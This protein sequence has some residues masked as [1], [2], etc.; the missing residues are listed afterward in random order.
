M[1]G[2][3]KVI[4]VCLTK[5]H[6]ICRADYINRLHFLSE[7]AGCKMIVFNSFSD[8]Y[9]ND[10]SD[11]GA[12]SVYG[13]I[14]FDIVDVLVVIYNSFHNK[15][16]IED[17]VSRAKEAGKPVIIINGNVDGCWSIC[18]DYKDTYKAMLNHI[19]KDHGVDDTFFIAG[20]NADT[21]IDSITRLACY[22]EVL[23]EN[24]IP[25]DMKKVAYGDYWEFPVHEIVCRLIEYGQKPPKAIFCANDY[26]AFAACKTLKENGY[27]V[28]EDVIVTGFDGVPAAEYF[29]PQLTTCSEDAE[30][31]ARMTIG[32]VEK[33]VDE[34][35]PPENLTYGYKVVVSESCGCKKLAD[36][37]FRDT[38]LDLHYSISESE[39]HEGFIYAC[40]DHM[41]NINDMN[42]LCSCLA[43]TIL[44]NSYVCLN[45]NF[46]AKTIDAN[47]I[48]NSTFSDELIIINSSYSYNE[49]DIT[50]NI[51]VTDMVPNLEKWVDDDK[52]YYLTAIHSGSEVIGYYAA[53]TDII[54]KHASQINR[55]M[56]AITIAF[57]VAINHFR[58]VKMRLSLDTVTMTNPITSLPNFKGLSRWFEEFSSVQENHKKALSFSVYALPKY[59][60][61]QENYGMADIEA[62]VKFIGEALKIANP[63]NCF[64]AHISDDEFVVVNYYSDIYTISD[65][66]NNATGVFF[67]VVEGYNSTSGKEYY[68]EANA[69]CTVIDPDWN[70]NIEGYIK[71]ANSEMYM[72]RLKYGV[73]IGA[74]E[75]IAPKEHY[76]AFELLIEKNLFMYNFQPIVSA[77]TGEIFAFEALMRTDK[78]IGMNPLQVL[79]AAK[80]YNRL[81]DVEKATMFN[82]M[83]C[84]VRGK[85]YFGDRK[86]F[87]NTIPG[88]FLNDKDREIF[89]EKYGQYTSNCIFEITE[90]ESVSDEELDIIKKLCGGNNVAID[91]YGSGHSN[92]V[93]LMRYAPQIIKIDRFLVTDIH[94][95]QNKQM[96]VRTT[97]EFAKMNDI[98][99][100]AEGVETSNE[101]RMVIDLGVD[102]IQGYY[103]GKPSPEIIREIDPDIKKEIIWAN[104]LFGQDRS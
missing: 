46:V 83:E 50:T 57:N 41:L 19:I 34:K 7:E 30:M 102:Y 31:L 33:A 43:D 60:Y 79:A 67:S 4:G 84:Y 45:N 72:N 99:V 3:K 74:R 5:I 90:Q 68:V 20:T 71:C 17:I 76:K 70:G 82:V 13:I 35:L 25:F 22:K 62:A 18:S 24:G 93:N 59:T 55:V 96:F 10:A 44:E 32:T 92:I 88:H 29:S 66:I 47:T 69:G 16:I 91:D 95:D 40:I 15:Q 100:L 61:I 97:V 27:S 21:D 38:A 98:K 39:I 11:E 81:Y 104:P 54:T 89:S 52:S 85:D 53:R 80:E 37:S 6:D 8:F 94:K 23:E 48:N 2:N 58:Q 26:M 42:G 101:L 77:K 65:T 75:E 51:N 12:K 103:T 73:G 63:T 49:P 64:V 86:V 28:P 87:I 9:V 14:N 78:S 56:K 1:I 36:V